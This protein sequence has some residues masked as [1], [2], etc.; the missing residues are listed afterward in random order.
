M[1]S[2]NSMINPEFYFE[3]N[4]EANKLRR[5]WFIDENAPIDIF[6]II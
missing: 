4:D 3:M 5:E 1:R 2:M 6:A